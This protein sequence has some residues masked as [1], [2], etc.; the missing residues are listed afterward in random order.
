MKL[1]CNREELG[2]ALNVAIRA[3]NTSATL[4]SLQ[5]V[6]VTVDNKTITIRSTNLEVG[7]EIVIPSIDTEDGSVLVDPKVLIDS[8]KYSNSKNVT[9]TTNEDNSKSNIILVTLESGKTKLKILNCEDFP[10]IPKQK[11]GDKVQLKVKNIISGIRSVLYSVSHSIIKPE[12]ASVYIWKD[13]QQLVFV[14]TDSFRLAEKRVNQN[15]STVDDLSILIPQKNTQDLIGVLEQLDED[16]IVD[17]Y[18]DKDQFSLYAK[19]TYITLRT[20]DGA[21]P[22]YRKIIPTD[23]VT[24]VIV[25]KKDLSQIIKKAG[26]F[27]DKFN[28]IVINI[29]TNTKKITVSTVS[30]EVGDTEDFIV[31]VIEGENSSISLNHKYI[32]DCL[33][34]IQ[35]D[36]VILSFFGQG[37][38][39]V[40]KG[41][42]DK[43]FIY[44]V[45]PMNN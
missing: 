18:I 17:V 9:I 42:S 29:D 23:T 38:P 44:L 35:S 40:I 28:K 1:T 33:Q 12:L 7:I 5:G 36:S 45:M 14:A 20:I 34:S 19:N 16:E 30:G 2:T 41:A 37:K 39:M 15:L 24:E 13:D 25:L 31:G 10:N 26:I 6:L 8:I 4:E 11:T 27:S 43:S 22:D 3:V 32:I 21:F